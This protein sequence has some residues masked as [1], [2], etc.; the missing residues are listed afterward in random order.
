MIDLVSTFGFGNSWIT[1]PT[2]AVLSMHPLH[3]FTDYTAMINSVDGL[4]NI[5]VSQRSVSVHS[6]TLFSRQTL[7]DWMSLR[8]QAPAVQS[9]VRE[10]GPQGFGKT[11]PSDDTLPFIS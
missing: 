11:L 5:L 4:L 9:T 8:T 2:N 1:M 6:I 10:R 7:R 3:R